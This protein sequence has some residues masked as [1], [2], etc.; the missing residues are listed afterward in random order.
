MKHHLPLSFV[1]ARLPYRPS[2][3][4]P[5]QHTRC[6]SAT[7]LSDLTGLHSAH[8]EAKTQYDSSLINSALFRS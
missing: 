3:L 5:L 4:K 2:S 1:A 7:L 8:H 6:R